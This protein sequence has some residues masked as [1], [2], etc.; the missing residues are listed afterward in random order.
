LKEKLQF[1]VSMIANFPQTIWS[2]VQEYKNDDPHLIDA[3]LSDF[4]S[5]D[6]PK[7][8]YY[9]WIPNGR[10]YLSFG[11]N[12]GEILLEQWESS[13]HL[14]EDFQKTLANGS[15][16]FDIIF[17]FPKILGDGIEHER[18]IPLGVVQLRET[19]YAS[20]VLSHEKFA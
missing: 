14:G 4:V 11:N 13:G 15:E 10:Q 2:L 9:G 8:P 17:M 3:I 6:W 20:L 5:S 7:M 18:F 12:F 16:V 19:I 1:S